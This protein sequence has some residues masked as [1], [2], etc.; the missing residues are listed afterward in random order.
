MELLKSLFNIILANIL[1]NRTWLGLA[2]L[3]A[4]SSFLLLTL[5]MSAKAQFTVEVGN[6]GDAPFISGFYGDEA[7][8]PRYRWT[9]GNNTVEKIAKGTVTFPISLPPSSSNKLIVTLGNLPTSLYTS[10][11]LTAPIVASI[12]VNDKTV[13]QVQVAVSEKTIDQNI[14]VDLPNDF[15]AQPLQVSVSSPILKIPGDSRA[16]GV[17]VERVALESAPMLRFPSLDVWLWAWLY[18]AM[19]TLAIWRFRKKVL[20]ATAFGSVAFVPFLL[21]PLI[22]PNLWYTPYLLPIIA[23]VALVIAVITWRRKL[24]D[25]LLALPDA[26]E[27]GSLARNVLILATLAYALF[28]LIIVANMDFIGHAD[29]ADNG[30]VARNLIRGNGFSVDYA[31]QFYQ[32]YPHLPHPADTW[33]LLQPLMTAPFFLIFGATAFAAKLPNLLLM[34]VLA[35]AVFYYGSRYLNRKTGLG[36]ALLVLASPAFFDTVAYPLNDL[37]FTL[38]M[39]L[40]IFSFYAALVYQPVMGGADVSAVENQTAKP[41]SF[42]KIKQ[43][44]QWL[45]ETPRKL[46]LISGF[47]GGLLI[48]SK[49]SSSAILAALGLAA[50][51]WKLWL[52]CNKQK[53]RLPWTNLI[54]WGIVVLLVASPYFVRNQI[55]FGKPVY[56]TESYDTWINKWAQNDENIYNLYY[57]VKQPLPGPNLL[58]FYG[59]DSDFKVVNLQFTKQLNDLWQG[60]FEAPLLLILAVLGIAVWPRRRYGLIQLTGWVFLCYELFI[61]IYWHYEPRYFLAWRPWLY[62]Y[63][64]YGLGWIF[65]KIKSEFE[66]ANS[67]RWRLGGWLVA[68]A[69]VL[70]FWPNLNQTIQNGVADTSPTGI[71]ITADWIKNHL[72]NDA[73]IMSRNVWELSFHADRHSVM[74]PNNA[75]LPQIKQAM[76]DYNVRYIELDHINVTNPDDPPSKQYPDA[77]IWQQRRALWPLITR[78]GLSDFTK[79]YDQNGFLIYQWDGK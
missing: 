39:W 52:W 60:N 77:A 61:N 3:T 2:L 36:A 35:W 5:A 49:P 62:L 27:Q 44:Q 12:A 6:L 15:L 37:V 17:R 53:A 51:A 68:G 11:V 23:A 70:L 10:K 58:L 24:G 66:Q 34:L 63:G 31:A 75:T 48:I 30:V 25:W 67:Q 55:D 65:G 18:L 71:V 33:P 8:A 4:V 13:K 38:L 41:M 69:F 22:L 74:I 54:L 26:L 40:T 45:W 46:Y 76:R 9:S 29:Y 56:S 21:M 14:E 43:L 1:K 32:F 57:S 7:G 47:W 50:I 16:L 79:I 28:S 42:A 73:V 59:F 64:I 78:A 19:A 72:P 20:A